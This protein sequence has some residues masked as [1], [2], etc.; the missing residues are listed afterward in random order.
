MAQSVEAQP[1]PFV[2][3]SPSAGDR[4]RDEKAWNLP[5][6][7]AIEPVPQTVAHDEEGL[8]WKR[9]VSTRFPGIRRHN[10]AALVAYSDHKRS[11]GKSEERGS[12]VTPNAKAPLIE[13]TSVAEWENEGGAAP[14]DPP[15]D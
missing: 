13:G 15:R 5:R 14:A 2:R 1:A 12:G 10:F 3:V 8:D 9:F 6:Q 11:V 4:E 7:A